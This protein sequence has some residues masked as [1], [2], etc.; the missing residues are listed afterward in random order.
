MGERNQKVGKSHRIDQKDLEKW[1][2]NFQN[3]V[4]RHL[5]KEYTGQIVL[6]IKNGQIE[7]IRNLE[8]IGVTTLDSIE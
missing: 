1:I 4:V 6:S 2:G 8:I 7:Y 3:L 5:N